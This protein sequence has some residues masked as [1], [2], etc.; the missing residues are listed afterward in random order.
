[1]TV[2]TLMEEALQLPAPEREALCE[3][4]WASLDAKS[5]TLSPDQVEE[6]ERRIAHYEAQPDDVISWDDVKAEILEKRGLKL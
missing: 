2:D 1:M 6:L 4:L 3:R 5:E